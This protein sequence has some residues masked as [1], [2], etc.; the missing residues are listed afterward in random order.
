[1]MN[2]PL[3][4]EIRRA[5]RE[6]SD[7]LGPDLDGLVERYASLESRFTRPC[8]TPKDR[9]PKRCTEAAKP[10]ELAME[11]QSSPPGDLGR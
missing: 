6:I 2:D 9:R 5:R 10:G 8:L 3:I 4:D 7:E 11:N 1:M